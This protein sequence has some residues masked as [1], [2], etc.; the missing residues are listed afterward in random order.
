MPGRTRRPLPPLP[1]LVLLLSVVLAMLGS[2]AFAVGGAVEAVVHVHERAAFTLKA[3]RA[4]QSAADRARAASQ[5]LDTVVDQAETAEARV[6]EKDGVAVV[7][8]GKTPVITLGDVD[9]ATT[10]ETLHVYASS[11]ASRAQEAVRAEETR[12]SIAD[13]VFSVSLLVFTGLLA[14]LLFRFVSDRAD[15]AQAWVKANPRRIPALR[16]GRIEVVRPNAVRGGVNIALGLAKL[17]TQLA[18]GYAWLAFALSRFE[19]TRSYTDRLTGF[20]LEPLWGLV[21]RVGGALPVVVVASIAALA[22]GV[23][24]RFVALFFESVAEGST[25][26]G[27]LPR[28][29]AAPT[30]MLARAG[31]IVAALV[32]AAPLLTGT[33]NGALSRV[34]VAVLFAIGLSC[35]PV[36]ACVVAGIPI[37]FGRRFVAGDFVEVGEH[38]GRVKGVSLLAVTL[39]GGDG[40]E[41]RVP[42][43]VALVRAT[44]VIGSVPPVSIEVTID[45]RESQAKV[46]ERLLAIAGPFTTRTKV[47][48][49]SLDGGG[50]R[51]RVSG[52]RIEGAGDLASTLADALRA[53]NVA[54]GRAAR[55]SPEERP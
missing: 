54:L 35:T 45:A 25:T 29:L 36:I 42:H 48:L 16:L 34:G 4:G 24:V 9:A 53:E 26:V 10:G 38:A 46:R 11:I 7:F 47:E 22:V 32:L 52:C 43:L 8:F 3:D 55:T 21:G 23:L 2:R 49:L 31:I 44:R 27:W 18:I 15:V 41:L 13:T 30:S 6:E 19:A 50:A 33:D 20:V 28:D 14:F 40:S 37:V 1:W 51:Y 17:F 12:R 5:A 39:E